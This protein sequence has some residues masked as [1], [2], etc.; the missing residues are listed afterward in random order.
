MAIANTIIQIKKSV[1]TG[2]TPSSLANGEIAINSADGKLFYR[3]PGGSIT[4]ITNQSTFATINAN[5]SLILAGTPTDTLSIVAGNNISIATNTSTKTITISSTATGGSGGSINS[6]SYRT[7]VDFTAT[8]NQNVFS[9]QYSVG[10]V[11]VYRNGLHLGQSDFIATDGNNIVLNVPAT[12][13]DLIT[14]ESFYTSINSTNSIVTVSNT[15]ASISTNTG[16]LIVAGGV[17]VGGNVYANS[18]YFNG[19]YYA[20]NGAPYTPPSV[21]LSDSIS[22]NSSVIAASS[23][24]VFQAV[25]TALAFSIA[26]G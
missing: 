22:S 2:N 6:Y 26:L 11:D 3:T 4:Y 18:V 12:A 15:T 24:A 10:S 13:G 21:T 19:L 8:S 16:A 7:V 9:T 25:S 14:I 1:V 5:N 23:N 17:G 20:A